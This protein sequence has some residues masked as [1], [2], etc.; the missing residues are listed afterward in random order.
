VTSSDPLER[1]LHP[2]SLVLFSFSAITQLLPLVVLGLLSGKADFEE[3]GF[4][5][6]IAVAAV[7]MGSIN[8]FCFRYRIDGE[9]ISTRSGL[10]FRKQRQLR[11][12]QVQNLS[13][14]RSPLHRLL[15]LALV[16]VESGSGVGDD[17]RLDGVTLKQ[18]DELRE[19]IGGKQALGAEVTE[20]SAPLL[21]LSVPELIRLGLISNRG[22]LVVAALFGFMMQNGWGNRS[23]EVFSTAEPLLL[24]LKD[25]HLGWVGSVLLALAAFLLA[26]IAL[27]MLSVAMS[28]VQFYGFELSARHD[29]VIAN[30]GLLTKI[31][32]A[33]KYERIQQVLI[34][35]TL[36]HRAFAQ[37]SVRARSAA[38]QAVNEGVQQ[39]S[40]LAPVIPKARLEEL[41]K[42]V[43]PDIE[44]DAF[45][46]QPIGSN[47]LGLVL[48]VRGCLFSIVLALGC[49]FLGV[50]ALWLLAVLPLLGW[51]AWVYVKRTRIH[52]SASSVAVFH[53][54]FNQLTIVSRTPRIQALRL[55]Q[56]PLER[57]FGLAS[58]DIDVAG[59]LA[60]GTQ[61]LTLPLLETERARE[62]AARLLDGA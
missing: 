48:L 1:R 32:A 45:N 43:Q 26:L 56:S 49:V 50:Q 55:R 53:G 52:V 30:Y 47:A 37:S 3:I 20:A 8:Y 7:A 10:L 25:A 15:N 22:M 58:V 31:Q 44:W 4:W 34:D 39:L 2:A 60:G 5:S 6:L 28:I 14:V 29:R 9:H 51:S 36:L 23:R 18:V 35:E 42:R 41:L 24:Q 27:R 40:W 21:R 59:S 12:A 57:Q 16:R 13:V 33:L 19:L 11:F 62:L 46:W 17:V 54:G 38:L 61:Q